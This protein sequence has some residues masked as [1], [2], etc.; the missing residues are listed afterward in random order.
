MGSIPTPGIQNQAVTGKS[1]PPSEPRV[2]SW[3][4]LGF[5]GLTQWTD[6]Q[7][8]HSEIHGGAHTWKDPRRT[9]STRLAARGFTEEVIGRALNNAPSVFV[10]ISLRRYSRTMAMCTSGRSLTCEGVVFDLDSP[11]HFG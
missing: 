8:A 1:W 5:E 2:T 10:L 6:E 11:R 3:L 7:R 4:T 9:V